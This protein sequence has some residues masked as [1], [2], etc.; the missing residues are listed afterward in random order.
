VADRPQ[1]GSSEEQGQQDCPGRD[2]LIF[3]DWWCA[4]H[5]SPSGYAR[6]W[7]KR[8]HK[9]NYSIFPGSERART[10]RVCGTRS[11]RPIKVE[12]VIDYGLTD[13]VGQGIDAGV[14]SGE[15]VARDMI[16]VRIGPDMRMA[17]LGA[18]CPYR[19]LDSRV[20]IVQEHVCVEEHFLETRVRDGR[21]IQRR[22]WHQR[23]PPTMAIS[24]VPTSSLVGDSRD[25]SQYVRAGR[26]F[27]RP[28]TAVH[29]IVP[30]N[31]TPMF[32][33]NWSVPGGSPKPSCQWP[34]VLR[35]DSLGSVP[36]ALGDLHVAV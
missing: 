32:I 14:R 13:I 28:R 8:K 25:L 17:V 33:G 23:G 1:I 6:P 9:N 10:Q 36:P 11:P 29:C 16:A 27:E 5:L 12:I 22:V 31:V 24:T 15:Q 20:N 19:K 4:R 18:C 7:T 35:R 3:R 26:P 30:K 21:Q 34:G 2:A